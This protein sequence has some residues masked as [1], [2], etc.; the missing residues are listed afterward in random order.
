M[1]I[2][3]N[4]FTERVVRHWNR[5]P[6]EVL[7]SQSPELLKKHVGMVVMVGLDDL[8]ALFQSMIVLLC[9]VMIVSTL[10][11]LGGFVGV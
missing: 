9:D 4:V 5:L 7:E 8:R 10:C 2:G 3:K 11:L 6:R 1:D